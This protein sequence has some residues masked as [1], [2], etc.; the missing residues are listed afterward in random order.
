MKTRKADIASELAGGGV[1]ACDDTFA[2]FEN[3][4]G[5]I[6]PL[7]WDM[8]PWEV[9]RYRELGFMASH[10][11]EAAAKTIRPGDK[12]CAVIGRLANTLWEKRL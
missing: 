12:E 7:R 4:G 2:G 5:A 1:I 10:C 6:A 11:L 8:T 3:A 9:E